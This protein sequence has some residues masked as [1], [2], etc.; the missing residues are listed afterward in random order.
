MSKTVV[1]GGG[2]AG[3]A[4]AAAMARAGASV[5]LLERM[6]ILGGLGLLAGQSNHKQFPVREELRLMG[7]YDMFQV[8]DNCTLH[9]SVKM[10]LPKPEG[11]TTTIYD[12]T[13]LDTELMKHLEGIGV[14]V[15]LMSRVKDIKV[16]GR[17]IQSVIL[18][19]GQEIQGDAF[20][21]ATGSAGGIRNC[22]TYGNGCVMCILRCPA[23]GDR[24]SIA[25]KAGVKEL[26]GKRRDGSIGPMSAAYALVKESLANDLREELER[27]G[28]VCIPVPQELVNYKRTENITA[29]G[30]IDPGFAENVV[31]VDNGYAKRVA[32][33]YT[34]L[35][36][37]RR[38]PGL[39]RARYA[40]PYAGT[41]GNA[42]RFMAITPRDSALNVPGV[43]NLFVA[44]E[45]VG[46]SSIAGTIVTGVVAGH[47]AARRA[48][49]MD[50]LTLPRT[51]IVGDFLAYVNERWDKEGL[52]T[53]FN[54][55][56]GPYLRRAREIGLYTEDKGVIRS[57][58][59]TSGLTNVFSQK[60]AE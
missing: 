20:V 27:T 18:D 7:A 25:A 19:D 8:L 32:A 11:R 1:V 52:T 2:F 54:T 60:L 33:G 36:E 46:V 9:E 14:E 55:H 49:H 59:E 4:A 38:I 26:M 22:Q 29:S 31:L 40:D 41:I 53:R 51:T 47:N 43:E 3:C 58:I 13:R 44:S 48:A 35:H 23:F 21:D 12:V 5:T 37:L 50:L 34:P 56:G 28:Y 24:V 30:N 45:K 10:P 17:K 57:R 39:E 16:E 15:R 6:E 42:I